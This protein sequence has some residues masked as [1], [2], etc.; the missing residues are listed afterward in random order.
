MAMKHVLK[1]L[2]GTTQYGLKYVRS[3][4]EEGSLGG[5]E[6]CAQVLFEVQCSMDLDMSTVVKCS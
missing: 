2:R 3:G 1:Y 5:N 6:A 4:G